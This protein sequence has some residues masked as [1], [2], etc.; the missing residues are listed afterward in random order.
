M[1]SDYKET[2]DIVIPTWNSLPY[3]EACLA[4]IERHTKTP[5]RLLIINNGSTDGTKRY[6]S[7]ICSDIVLIENE[8][9]LGYPH[10][11]FQGYKM[12]TS[13]IVCLMNDDVIVSPNWLSKLTEIMDENK[14]IGILGPTRTGAH[15]IHPYTN[16]L[17]KSLLEQSKF[18]RKT[19]EGQLRYFTK[20]KLY[21]VFIADY[22]KANKTGLIKY[23]KLPHIISTC[24]SIVRREAVDKAGGIVDINFS[25]YGA[26]D[27]DLC[28]RL[29]RSGYKLA[30]TDEV[31]VHHFEHV[32]T[33]RNKLDRHKH[34][35]SNTRILYK[36]WKKEIDDYLSSK[37]AAGYSKDDML[38]ES[39]LL[40]RIAN[41]VG[42]SFWKDVT[43]S[44]LS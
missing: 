29:I 42:S 28:W 44:K 35:V 27:T 39:W 33:D 26:D 38:E 37:I 7:T 10:A 25:K 23:D 2:V 40:K 4:S 34:L 31:Y 14:K 15:F 20:G 30:I 22:L 21:T 3:L 17:S 12:T 13:T 8:A 41:A 18:K 19:P 24:C 11:L 9:N 1:A 32:S 6:L 43:H 36:K 16:K 5:Y